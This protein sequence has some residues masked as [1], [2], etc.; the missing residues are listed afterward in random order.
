[1]RKVLLAHYFYLPVSVFS[2]VTGWF[3]VYSG[4]VFG[5]NIYPF[6]PKKDTSFRVIFEYRFGK[7]ARYV[8][9]RVGA[10]WFI[11]F[12]H[13]APILSFW[14]GLGDGAYDASPAPLTWGRNENFSIEKC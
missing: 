12:S 5:F 9:A 14:L 3:I 4:L 1:V 11:D 2:Y 7:F 8:V 6:F 13:S 10:S